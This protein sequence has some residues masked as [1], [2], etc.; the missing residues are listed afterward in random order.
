MTILNSTDILDY[1]SIVV[2]G[3]IE[4][5]TGEN[6]CTV[7]IY[8]PFVEHGGALRTFTEVRI[9]Y[10]CYSQI[11]P[12]TPGADSDGYTAFSE[13]DFVTVLCKIMGDYPERY[14]EPVAVTGFRDEIKECFRSCYLLG[15]SSTRQKLGAYP[16]GE[17]I[18]EDGTNCSSENVV[19]LDYM[20]HLN[21]SYTKT[22]QVGNLLIHHRQNFRHL[23]PLTLHNLIWADT[24][25]VYHIDEDEGPRSE[26]RFK[27]FA[28]L[29]IAIKTLQVTQT[30]F[31]VTYTYNDSVIFT[32]DVAVANA[33]GWH[34][35]FN[36]WIKQDDDGT[37]Y[38]VLGFVYNYYTALWVNYY[39]YGH[40]SIVPVW[41]HI[42]SSK[43]ANDLANGT[44]ITGKCGTSNSIFTGTPDYSGATGN[45]GT[46]FSDPICGQALWELHAMGGAGA[47][48][49]KIEP[50]EDGF[51]YVELDVVGFNCSQVHSPPDSQ[52]Y[53]NPELV[54]YDISTG[55]K[56][57][58]SLSLNMPGTCTKSTLACVPPQPFKYRY[59]YEL[60]ED[61]YIGLLDGD[62]LYAFR[63]CDFVD[64]A[65]D[66]GGTDEWNTVI[67]YPPAV[68]LDNVIVDET[69]PLQY[70]E[71]L[72]YYIKL[73]AGKYFWKI[74]D[75]LDHS[76]YSTHQQGVL[77]KSYVVTFI[78]PSGSE[79]TIPLLYYKWT[80]GDVSESGIYNH[81]DFGHSADISF[82]DT[83]T[84]FI[85]KFNS[86][87]CSGI[88]CSSR[89]PYIWEYN[90]ETDTLRDVTDLFC[91]CCD[92][93]CDCNI[94]RAFYKGRETV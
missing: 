85:F 1:E 55:V 94:V 71:H 28:E 70:G 48:A 65:S 24:L 5:I 50:T 86:M 72:F 4:V 37:V 73:K 47:L 38:L 42:D 75:N 32:T 49:G 29:T 16:D 6:E 67:S 22:K 82:I 12:T 51:N 89:Y 7:T 8:D 33:A 90:K 64:N 9:H 68:P 17:I 45:L 30:V 59:E 88:S 78:P 57:R 11:D 41:V 80:G 46:L 54:E 23:Y 69:D 21:D 91:D 43:V 34:V 2:E 14:L 76:T 39:P 60:E 74:K 56:S 84:R 63:Q 25:E 93:P 58:S 52:P 13:D 27:K 10:H 61:R 15:R 35:Y 3:Q 26:D 87:I 66:C 62:V 79:F 36:P 18:Q 40:E 44:R 92:S 83:E 20:S 77:A 81:D 31:T 19:L 53:G